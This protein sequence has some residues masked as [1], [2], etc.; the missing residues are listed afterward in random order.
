MVQILVQKIRNTFFFV[1]KIINTNF[2]FLFCLI[3]KYNFKIRTIFSNKIKNI[4]LRY[5][6]LVIKINFSNNYRINELF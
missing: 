1:E 6:D 3:N 4:Y 5:L 2:S